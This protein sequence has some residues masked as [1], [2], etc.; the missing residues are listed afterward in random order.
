D[1]KS[2]AQACTDLTEKQKVFAVLN[3]GYYFDGKCLTQDHQSFFAHINGTSDQS[4]AAS[5]GREISAGA[6]GEKTLRNL[7]EAY[8]GR[9]D[10]LGLGGKVVGTVESPDGDTQN[11]INGGLIPALQSHGHSP[12]VRSKMVFPPDPAAVQSMVADQQRAGVTAEFLVANAGILQMFIQTADQ[13][14]FHP[15]YYTSDLNSLA[16]DPLTDTYPSSSF[17]GAVGVTSTRTGDGRS[18]VAEPSVDTT[19]RTRYQG[20]GGKSL[21]RNS[22][23][24]AFMERY[25]GL[26]SDFTA[27]VQLAG[28][29]LTRAK[30]SSAYRSLGSHA[31]PFSGD[32]SYGPNKLTGADSQRTVQWHAGA[33]GC[34]SGASGCYRPLD[35]PGFVP[36]RV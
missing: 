24:Y 13:A 17:D 23:D 36:F 2:Q 21:D 7:V 19:C 32:I 25:C 30:L 12:A 31:Y 35:G 34:S 28:P 8:A 11:E 22:D 18:G 6:S 27:A 20:A 10:A 29:D 9:G 14:G 15:R 4:Y 3:E 33:A 5:G 1:E 26:I 16:Q